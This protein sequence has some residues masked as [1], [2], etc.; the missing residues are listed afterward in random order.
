MVLVGSVA[1][2]VAAVVVP[3]AAAAAVVART[4]N[5]GVT[6][7]GITSDPSRDDIAQ[8]A[9]LVDSSAQCALEVIG[10]GGIEH[11][12]RRQLGPLAPHRRTRDAGLA[13]GPGQGRHC[14]G[15]LDAAP[16]LSILGKISAASR[17][18]SPHWTCRNRAVPL[19][20]HS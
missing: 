18:R 10:N 16:L 19:G 5:V 7:N 3:V 13:D 15:S 6:E 17:N 4:G 20:C 2:T 11:R 12:L 8:G 14:C 9:V 1:E